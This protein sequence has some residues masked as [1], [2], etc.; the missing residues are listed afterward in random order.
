MGDLLGIPALEIKPNP[1]IPDTVVAGETRTSYEVD[2][3]R[4]L[5]LPDE[6]SGIVFVFRTFE[7]ISYGMV[8]KS[9]RPIAIGDAVRTP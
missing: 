1:I 9:V 8:M 7:K 4:P 5:V 2:P 3:N 6:R